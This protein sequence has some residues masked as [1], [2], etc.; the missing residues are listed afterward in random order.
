MGRARE[1]AGICLLAGV[2]E[3]YYAGNLGSGL[4]FREDLCGCFE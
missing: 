2:R 4:E 3:N 1:C